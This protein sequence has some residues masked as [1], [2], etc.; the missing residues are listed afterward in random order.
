MGITRTTSGLLVY[1]EFTFD[2]RSLY[3]VSGPDYWSV[4]GGTMLYDG[5]DVARYTGLRRADISTAKCVSVRAREVAHSP[6]YT[7]YLGVGSSGCDDA[8]YHQPNGYY[9]QAQAHASW[10]DLR[11]R[12]SGTS[13][14]LGSTLVTPVA[15][16]AGTYYL[17]RLYI[18]SGH[19]IGKFGETALAD[20]VDYDDSGGSPLTEGHVYFWAHTY[21]TDWDWLEARTS[22]L[23]TVTGLPTGY[24]A[25]VSDGTTQAT[26]AE[27]SGTATI[28]AGLLLFPLARVSVYDGDPAGSGVEVAYLTGSTIVD[29]GG[30]DTFAYTAGG[31]YSWRVRATDEHGM[32]GD[33]STADTFAVAFSGTL[34]VA[35]LQSLS[36][37]TDT[38][39][40]SL[41]SYLDVDGDSQTAYQIVTASDPDF[42]AD[43]VDSGVV[44]STDLFHQHGELAEGLWYRKLR[45]RTGAYD[46]SEWVQDTFQIVAPTSQTAEWEVYLDAEKVKAP[47]TTALDSESEHAARNAKL[48]KES[49]KAF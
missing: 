13:T 31:I 42:T 36:V 3:T 27:S 48:V 16:V 11:K 47:H 32:V 43:V 45:I 7:H 41:W 29:M 21:D 34:P 12:V 33:W 38:T 15:R 30:G 44:V 17:W 10:V 40:R 5:G 2:T 22:H 49:N 1:D 18:A 39:P 37:T 20:L 9:L 8:T 19:V 28:D 14:K 23:I 25:G 46:W 4:S 35:T 6:Y 24:Y 26:A